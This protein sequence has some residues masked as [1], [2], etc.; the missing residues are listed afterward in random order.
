MG[1]ILPFPVRSSAPP[2]ANTHLVRLEAQHWENQYGRDA[3][4]AFLLKH[5][6]RPGPAEAEVIGKIV[7]RRVKASD[8]FRYPKL[9]RAAAS[10]NGDRKKWQEIK[11]RHRGMTLVEGDAQPQP[12]S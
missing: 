7:G 2:P 5:G 11:R 3:Y 9:Y 10:T 8:G 6:N 4:S 1:S 12:P